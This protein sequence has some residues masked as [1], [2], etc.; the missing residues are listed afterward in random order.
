MRKV[1]CRLG[2]ALFML[3]LIAFCF[4]AVMIL[5]FLS[6]ILQWSLYFS[7]FGAM[8][9]GW[10]E[11]CLFG[12]APVLIVGILVM[13]ISLFIPKKKETTQAPAAYGGWNCMLCGTSNTG[14]STVCTACGNPRYAP[15]AA[16]EPPAP[17]VEVAPAPAP[18]PVTPK[19][20]QQSIQGFGQ[21]V[22]TVTPVPEHSASRVQ[23]GKMETGPKPA[24]SPRVCTACG[25]EIRGKGKFCTSCGAPAPVEE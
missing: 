18:V 14:D 17:R 24:D 7:G 6:R 1:M 3:G 21:G 8:P 20:Q 9:M 2:Y 5:G 22:P 25:A 10:Q 13:I 16:A 12:G 15:A 4:G 19:P 11:Y 23:F